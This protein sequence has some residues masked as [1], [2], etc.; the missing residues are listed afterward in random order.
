MICAMDGAKSPDQRPIRAA[1][2]VLWRPDP[3]GQRLAV[4][5]R[6][7]YDDWSFPK[8]KAE[9]DEHTLLAAV[10]E[11]FEETGQ[12]AVLGRRLPTVGYEVAGRPKQVRYWA[13]RAVAG[14]GFEPGAEVD[15]VAW[16]TPQEARGRLTREWD[17][18]LLDAFLS[19][20]A[21]TVPVVLLRHGSAEQR[22]DE[23]PDDLLRPLADAGRRQARTLAELVATVVPGSS[24]PD[25][26]QSQVPESLSGLIAPGPATGPR[27]LSSPARRCLDTVRPLG[28]ALGTA[29][30]IEPVLAQYVDD[31]AMPG[32]GAWLAVLLA[33]ERATVACSHLP[34]LQELMD[35][36]LSD[37][38]AERGPWINGRPWSRR[39]ARRL[40]DRRLRPGGG[41]VLHLSPG[42]GAHGAAELVAVDRVRAKG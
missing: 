8:G 30:E 27:L 38:E 6:P 16:L 14:P 18:A 20:P 31:E 32:A 9:P 39:E 42:T 28:D 36:V 1:G 33:E 26:P 34:V 7:R 3:D 2:A 29:V 23:Y 35:C 4:V 37:P 10:R 17:V 25:V 11:V 22:S 41:W 21:S 5:H 15:E 19:A 12:Q 13:A 40:M 24:T